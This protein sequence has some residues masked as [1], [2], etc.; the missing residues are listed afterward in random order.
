MAVVPVPTAPG[1]LPVIALSPGHVQHHERK[2]GQ[3]DLGQRFL[4]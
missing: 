2:P 3:T 1:G 4:H